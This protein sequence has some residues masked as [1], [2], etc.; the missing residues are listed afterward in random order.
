M[1]LKNHTTSIAAEKTAGEVMGILG[2]K[3][4]ARIS[5]EYDGGVLA[6]M[7]FV[8][9]TEYGPQEYVLP[10]RAD[11][12]LRAMERDPGVPAS[13]CTPEQATRVAWRTAKEW[14]E[15]QI[16]LVDAGLAVLDEVMLPYAIS[17]GGQTM[18]QLMRENR[19]QALETR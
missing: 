15:V 1:T 12:M 10:V 5:M 19:M 7:S 8:L 13:K 9:T 14:L 6:G 17:D 4:A 3:G 18:Y 16:A 2:A 11:G